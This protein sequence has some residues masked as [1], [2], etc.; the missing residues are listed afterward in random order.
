MG[1]YGRFPTEELAT[2]RAAYLNCGHVMQNGSFAIVENMNI[3][4]DEHG[5]T[6]L[7][8]DSSENVG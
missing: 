1:E 2:Q 7:V 6:I 3:M 8:G 4:S 5:N